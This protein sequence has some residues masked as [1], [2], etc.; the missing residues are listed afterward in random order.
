[1]T[2]LTHVPMVKTAMVKTATPNSLLPV[3]GPLA[4]IYLKR[5]LFT[6]SVPYA[7]SVQ[8]R[9]PYS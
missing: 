9:V 5:R 6:T 3:V 8:M 1:M 2:N 7:A 4:V